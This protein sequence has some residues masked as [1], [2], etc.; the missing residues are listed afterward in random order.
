MVWNLDSEEIC[1]L[2]NRCPENLVDTS[3]RVK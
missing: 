2:E 1:E 3:E